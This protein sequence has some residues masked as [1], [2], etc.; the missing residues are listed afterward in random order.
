MKISILIVA[1]K[2]DSNIPVFNYF[3]KL[4]HNNLDYEVLLAEGN[5]PSSQRNLLANNAQGEYILF[6]DDDSWPIED[7]LERYRN[8]II[9]NPEAGI[10]GGPSILIERQ[11][12]IYILSN[13]FFSSPFGIGPIRSRYNSIGSTRKASERELILCNLLMRK[14]FFLTT[15]GFN[16]NIHPGEE[17]EFLK[18]HQASVGIIYDPKAIVFREPRDSFFLFLQQMY[19]YGNGRS[20]HLK[21]NCFFE[22][23]FLIPLFFSTYILSLPFLVGKSYYF[24]GPL[25]FHF[26]LSLLTLMGH[27]MTKLNIVPK[28]LIPCFFFAG[29]FAYGVGFIAGVGE[30]KM[31]KKFTVS[32]KSKDPKVQFQLHKLKNFKISSI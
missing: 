17:N 26:I 21:L 16:Q 13:V 25:L 23:L 31:L 7:I 24:C 2:L 19:S 15:N 29:H 28:C 27:K 1:K 14:D 8:T 20:K 11:N 22:Y 18:N 10:I 12:L 9:S 6:F 4:K 30:Y 3:K 32:E 5:N